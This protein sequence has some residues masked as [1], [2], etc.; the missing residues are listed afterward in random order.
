MHQHGARVR[1]C[2]GGKVRSGGARVRV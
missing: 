1:R 2:G